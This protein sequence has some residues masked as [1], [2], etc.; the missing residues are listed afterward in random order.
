MPRERAVRPHEDGSGGWLR[1]WEEEASLGSYCEQ[2]KWE[3]KKSW[4]RA[5]PV[6]N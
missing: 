4:S 5:I 6:G 3:A 1:D 2:S